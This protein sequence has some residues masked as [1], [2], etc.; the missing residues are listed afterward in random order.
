MTTRR[1]P[2]GTYS[3]SLREQRERRGLA[4]PPGPTGPSGSGG[5]GSTGATGATGPVGATGSAGA[6]G[7]AGGTY[8]HIQATPSASWHVIHNLGF[9]PAVSAFDSTDR[10][11]EGDVTHNSADDLTITFSAALG[12]EA[13]LS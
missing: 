1:H 8:Q 2:L 10:Q 9:R 5:G 12:G 3:E 13:D 6:T 7:A 4:G 11:V